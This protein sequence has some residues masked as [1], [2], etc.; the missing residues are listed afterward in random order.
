[1]SR[2]RIIID[3]DHVVYDFVRTFAEWLAMNDALDDLPDLPTHT[4]HR[5]HNLAQFITAQP[6][7]IVDQAM[8]AYTSW[9]LHDNW[10]MSKGEWTRW[11]RLGIEAGYMYRKGPLIPGARDAIWRLNDA[12][13]HIILA[14]NRLNVFG[15]H[16]KIIENSV[17]WLRDN[18]IPYRELMFTTDKTMVMADAIVDDVQ[19]NMDADMHDR[20]F[21]FPSNHNSD[22]YVT[23][24]EK[25]GTWEY[26]VDALT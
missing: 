6:Y 1:M 18:N 21:L 10:G 2:P 24:V 17:A 26:V 12:E 13:W 11:W 3:L 7:P 4:T 23:D 8:H 5:D 9:G 19:D 25:R 20:T 22:H 16:D 15:M 14:T